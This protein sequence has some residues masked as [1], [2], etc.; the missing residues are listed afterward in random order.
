MSHVVHGVHC[1]ADEIVSWP[2]F[3]KTCLWAR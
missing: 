2:F 1:E 3:M